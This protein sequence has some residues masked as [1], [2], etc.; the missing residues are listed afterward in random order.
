[1]SW[2]LPSASEVS[3]AAASSQ[4]WDRVERAR[5]PVARIAVGA[6]RLEDVT[7]RNHGGD[8]RRRTR[9]WRRPGAALPRSDRAVS[10]PFREASSPGPG[11]HDV[12][13]HAQRASGERHGVSG[14]RRSRRTRPTAFTNASSA[15]TTRP[16]E[17]AEPAIPTRRR[18]RARLSR[19]P[20]SARLQAWRPIHQ[21]HQLGRVEAISPPP[22]TRSARSTS[23]AR[24]PEMK[25]AGR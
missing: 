8:H 5:S 18:C 9:A 19:H 6:P 20:Q 24:R 16:P 1:M 15:G 21:S 13:R 7:G 17:I 10:H 12:H 22:A 3:S 2:M 4:P 11:P 25:T 14:T 23:P